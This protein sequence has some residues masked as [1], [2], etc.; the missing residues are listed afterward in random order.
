DSFVK[1]EA[2]SI[3]IIQAKKVSCK[4]IEYYLKKILDCELPTKETKKKLLIKLLEDK[5]NEQTI[6]E[7]PNIQPPKRDK[8]K[9]SKLQLSKLC[10]WLPKD[11]FIKIKADF[12]PHLEENRIAESTTWSHLGYTVRETNLKAVESNTRIQ[13]ESSADELETFHQNINEMAKEYSSSNKENIYSFDLE[14]DEDYSNTIT[15]NKPSTFNSCIT[16]NTSNN[17]IFASDNYIPFASKSYKNSLT[18]YIVSASS[19]DEEI[20]ENT[21]KTISQNYEGTVL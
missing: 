5:K 10:S 16:S 2:A 7:I 3:K 11:Y 9:A 4:E 17:M 13:V 21:E 6:I 14:S 1:K 8:A 18:N 20:T 19:S 15:I 12:A